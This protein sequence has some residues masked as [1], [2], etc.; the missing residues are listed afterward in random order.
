MLNNYG[1]PNIMTHGILQVS[2]TVISGIISVHQ[3]LRIGDHTHSSV[4][5][6]FPP[7]ICSMFYYV[8]ILSHAEIKNALHNVTK[9]KSELCVKVNSI[10][11][12]SKGS[13]KTC[14]F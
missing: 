2:T 9:T 5:K 1:K 7:P 4:T 11:F 3:V 14:N 13:R 12:G 10:E 6:L 8:L